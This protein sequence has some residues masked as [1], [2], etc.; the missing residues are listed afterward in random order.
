M[1]ETLAKYIYYRFAKHVYWVVILLSVLIWG[2]LYRWYIEH[3]LYPVD[4]SVR[5]MKLIS[6]SL[7]EQITFLDRAV[8]SLAQSKKMVSGK[9]PTAFR[10][11]LITTRLASDY[12]YGVGFFWDP[13]LVNYGEYIYKDGNNKI[14]VESMNDIFNGHHTK[15]Y[16]R[17]WF[18]YVVQSKSSKVFSPQ[19]S[20]GGDPSNTLTYAFPVKVNQQLIGVGVFDISMLLFGDHLDKIKNFE[21]GSNEN[22]LHIFY[23]SKPYQDLHNKDIYYDIGKN[24]NVIESPGKIADLEHVYKSM[25]KNEGWS[26]Y[27]GYIYR[28]I[29]LIRGE[30]V[31]I[32]EYNLRWVIIYS[33][34]WFF[35]TPIILFGLLLSL[36]K[37]LIKKLSFIVN[38]ISELSIQASKIVENQMQETFSL[39]QSSQIIEINQ[40]VYSLETMRQEIQKLLIKERELSKAQAEMLLASSIQKKFIPA[41]YQK[42]LLGSNGRKVSIAAEF[43]AAE[44]LSGDIYD[45]FIND[46]EIY[47]LIGDA[48]GKDITAALF[49]LF[50]LTHFR[51]L[52]ERRLLPHQIMDELNDY[53][54]S[55]N[56]ENMFISAI[57]AKIQINNTLYFSNAGH[58]PAIVI[59]CDGKIIPNIQHEPDLVLGV[60][61]TYHY[62]QQEININQVK[63][64][65]FFTDGITEARNGDEK[66][67]GREGV[68]ASISLLHQIETQPEQI[69]AGIIKDCIQFEN[70]NSSDDM[71]LIAVGISDRS[72]Q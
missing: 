36:K 46:D 27:K 25:T 30:L 15:Y 34:I 65:Y 7:E 40:L 45:V 67:Y 8:N 51:V 21:A 72:L 24:E 26:Y 39:N 12:F 71:T 28:D 14:V 69:A 43:H 53:V 42:F 6:N 16:L 57:C 33:C 38:P 31:F 9:D 59:D 55:M 63:E 23:L 5:N 37:I 29:T 2:S 66:M 70:G 48:T 4:S 50:V 54:C 49:A 47:I 11:F 56:A 52:C 61:P 19:I 44:Q 32:L 60:M 41:Q 64:I 58:E 18:T 62:Q 10:N 22:L 3:T 13:K 68:I 35:I 20:W 17:P 1:K